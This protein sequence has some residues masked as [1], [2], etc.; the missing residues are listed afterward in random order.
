MSY[1]ACDLYIFKIVWFDNFEIMN[2]AV[3]TDIEASEY[4]DWRNNTQTWLYIATE[5]EREKIR[6]RK[7]DEAQ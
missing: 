3:V 4:I 7:Q 6:E 2:D 5:R 1:E